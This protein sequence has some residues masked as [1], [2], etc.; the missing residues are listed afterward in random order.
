MLNIDVFG[1]VKKGD[2][3]LGYIPDDVIDKIRMHSDIVEVV[4]RYVQLKRKGKN[5]TGL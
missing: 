2:S 5:Y 1:F 3:P 4:S